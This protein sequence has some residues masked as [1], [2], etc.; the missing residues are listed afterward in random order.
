[1]PL[2]TLECQA[3]ESRSEAA[4]SIAGRNS[5][6]CACG[7]TN[8][9]V[10]TPV[11]IIGAM[12]SKPVPLANGAIQAQSN[13]EVRAYEAET[14]NHGVSTDSAEFKQMAFSMR[15]EATKQVEKMG[16]TSI[17]DFRTNHAK[18]VF[19]GEADAN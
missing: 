3:C 11:P 6:V 16:Y 5:S 9:V 10:I 15:N 2:Y 17:N 8:R 4:L 14:G 12:P 1:M 18:R 7:G 13:A 19:S